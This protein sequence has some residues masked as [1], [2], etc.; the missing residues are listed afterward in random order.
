AKVPE[1]E[2]Q[3]KPEK[4]TTDEKLTER[5]AHQLAKINHLNAKKPDAFMAALLANR[6]DLAG[7]PF[8][9][10]DDCRTS[11]DRLKHFTEAVN[12]V[13]QAMAGNRSVNAPPVNAPSASGRS[14]APVA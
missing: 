10:G 7:L 4:G 1:V 8:V 2:F 13:R 14:S 3:A 11:G 9:M 6:S 12:T 5:A